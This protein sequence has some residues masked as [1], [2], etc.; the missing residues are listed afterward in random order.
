MNFRTYADVKERLGTSAKVGF[1]FEF[2]VP[3]SNDHFATVEKERHATEISGFTTLDEFAEL[4]DIP[5]YSRREIESD[6]EGWVQSQEEDFVE[7]NWE[8]HFDE[9]E[10]IDEESA[11]DIARGDFDRSDYSF[12]QWLDSEFKHNYDFTNNYGLDPIYGWTNDN[13]GRHATVYTEP[14]EEA[15]SELATFTEVKQSLQYSALK[16]TPI[17]ISTSYHGAKGTSGW[18]IEPDSSIDGKG[19]GVELVS[20]PLLLNDALVVLDDVL[21][22][23]RDND[24]ETNETTGLHINV[25]VPNMAARIDPVKL[26]LFLGET[27]LLN[28]FGRLFNSYSKP[29]M[30]TITNKIKASGKFPAGQGDVLISKIMDLL[31]NDHYSAINFQ[32]LQLED[33]IEFRAAGNSDYHL[34]ADKIKKSVLR[35]VTAIE[36]ACDPAAERKEYLK[37]LSQLS[38]TVEKSSYVVSQAGDLPKQLERLRKYSEDFVK[39]WRGYTLAQ[40]PSEKQTAAIFIARAALEHTAKFNTSLN[41]T[42]KVFIRKLFTQ[43]NVTAD[44]LDDILGSGI[45][46]TSERFKF[47]KNY[48]I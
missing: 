4:F 48:G 45:Q 22:W 44:M 34:F 38:A 2:L 5:R 8:K 19:H 46:A 42:E 28:E 32:H 37:K 9:E 39:G 30:Q 35:I 16:N 26:V 17:T 23:M 12:E 47:K 31:A 40:S 27:H 36:I 7:D 15:D 33:Y 13:D 3:T 6:Y 11:R 41:L 14:E 18:R 21:E 24:I 1:E 10:G 25:S 29:Q 20:P 43:N